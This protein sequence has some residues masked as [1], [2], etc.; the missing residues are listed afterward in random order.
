MAETSGRFT[1]I[2]GHGRALAGALARF[3]LRLHRI[4]VVKSVAMVA[5][6]A[7]AAAATYVER[8]RLRH[9]L[10]DLAPIGWGWVLAG[11]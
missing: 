9:S 10:G 1:S 5:V 2:P 7:V 4:G 3:L 11:S 8:V 6:V